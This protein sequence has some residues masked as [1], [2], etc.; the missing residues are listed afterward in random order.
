M[1]REFEMLLAN[2]DALN[3]M[4]GAVRCFCG[5]RFVFINRHQYICMLLPFCVLKRHMHAF[6]PDTADCERP[7]GIV[8]IIRNSRVAITYR[9]RSTVRLNC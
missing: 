5:S 4:Y 6:L 9:L 2:I 1:E 7:K 8:F 3:I